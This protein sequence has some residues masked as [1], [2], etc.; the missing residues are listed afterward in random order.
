MIKVTNNQYKNGNRNENIKLFIIVWNDILIT[1]LQ[2]L[3][4]LLL[5]L[6]MTFQPV[7]ACKAVSNQNVMINIKVSIINYY[8]LVLVNN[9]VDIMK[10][11][12]SCLI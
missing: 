5:K 10:C 12:S 3:I 4:E 7:T 1:Q 11:D 8:K 9:N 2:C 6:I